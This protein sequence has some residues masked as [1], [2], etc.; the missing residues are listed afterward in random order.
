MEQRSGDYEFGVSKKTLSPPYTQY[1][2]WQ[3]QLYDAQPSFP[4]VASNA[5]TNI[6]IRTDQVVEL[7]YSIDSGAKI[8]FSLYRNPAISDDGTPID[9]TPTNDLIT[10][11]ENLF[12]GEV[13]SD[14]TITNSEFGDAIIDNAIRGA[15]SGPGN[16]PGTPGTVSPRVSRIL[17]PDTEYLIRTQNLGNNADYQSFFLE[18][19]RLTPRL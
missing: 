2:N 17:R 14:P 16:R 13:Y 7:S 19:T 4:S 10:P 11:A 9:V 5:Y 6:L 18:F 15:A 3:G 1:R 12:G 8:S